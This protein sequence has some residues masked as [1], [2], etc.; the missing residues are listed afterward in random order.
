[1][2]LPLDPAARAAAAGEREDEAVLRV[3]R[4]DGGKLLASQAF[5]AAEAL[6]VAAPEARRVESP[7]EVL[8]VWPG[9]AADEVRRAAA[10][11]ASAVG[12]GLVV[13]VRLG[14]REEVAA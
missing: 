14:T 8:A 2:T 9:A 4:A 11:A 1:V 12:E 10:R 6:R 3:A 7:G 13:S 5:R